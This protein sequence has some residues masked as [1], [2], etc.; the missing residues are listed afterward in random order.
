MT[1]RATQGEAM[2]RRLFGDDDGAPAFM[3]TLLP[4]QPATLPHGRPP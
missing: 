3:R 1:I 4:R 2:R